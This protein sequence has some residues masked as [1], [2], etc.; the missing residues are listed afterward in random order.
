MVTGSAPYRRPNHRLAMLRNEKKPTT[1]VTVVTKGLE[2]TA[3][4]NLSRCRTS[5]IRIP[6][7]AAA[8]R[9]QIMASPI[10]N[11]S[12]GTLAAAAR[13]DAYVLKTCRP[14]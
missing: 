1:S 13:V 6:P 3:G 12:P 4:S 14:D 10:T 7:R 2:A 5:G 9:L 8:I 11:P